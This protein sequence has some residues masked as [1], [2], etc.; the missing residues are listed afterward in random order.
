MGHGGLE[1]QQ[2]IP[3]QAK[4]GA[5]SGGDETFASSV[6][7]KARAATFMEKHLLLDTQAAGRMGEGGGQVHPPM[8]GPGGGPQSIFL[9]PDTGLKGLS[10]WAAE[11]GLSE[12]M[13]V[14]QGQVDRLMG[15]LHQELNALH[16]TKTLFQDQD[17]AAGAQFGP[18]YGA[19][20]P[21]SSFDQW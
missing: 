8:T 2:L 18:P 14:W 11:S 9:K 19:P 7:D 20:R 10:A 12:A 3:S 1:D 13:T 16:G 21:A 15:R 6:S 17:H 4:E 5:L